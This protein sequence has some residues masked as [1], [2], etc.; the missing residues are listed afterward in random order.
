MR[1][2]AKE[3]QRRP[4]EGRRSR[5]PGKCTGSRQKARKTAGKRPKQ[6]STAGSRKP[7]RAEG[8]RA[9]PRQPGRAARVAIALPF[10]ERQITPQTEQAGRAA[11][12]PANKF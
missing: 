7:G 11:R 5:R 6:R 10:A 8:S 4:Q 1:K 9:G 2:A 12:T 3:G